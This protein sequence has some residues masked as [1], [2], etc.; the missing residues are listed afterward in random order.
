MVEE[1]QK[2]TYLTIPLTL[3]SKTGKVVYN[4]RKQNGMADS[5]V[6]VN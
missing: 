5:G 3:I 4:D 6:Q 2:R 1:T